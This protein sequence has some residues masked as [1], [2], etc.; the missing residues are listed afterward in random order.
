[1]GGSELIYDVIQSDNVYEE[2]YSKP[3]VY[4]TSCSHAML[5]SCSVYS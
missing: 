1:M 2:I 3:Q 5:S 4:M